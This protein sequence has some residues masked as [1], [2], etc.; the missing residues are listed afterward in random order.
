MITELT[1][2]MKPEQDFEYLFPV[3][4]CTS[5]S[6]LVP[7]AYTNTTIPIPY[8]LNCHQVPSKLNSK[9]YVSLLDLE[10]LELS[11]EL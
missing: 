4:D 10:E 5:C 11:T 9:G 2:R 3:A 8:C 6:K 7:F 1:D